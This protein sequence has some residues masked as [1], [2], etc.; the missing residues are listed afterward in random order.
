MVRPPM[1]FLDLCRRSLILDWSQLTLA[2]GLR[3]A[4]AM[5]LVLLAGVLAGEPAAGAVAASG[6]F[7]VGFG[8]F[9]QFTRSHAGPM[10]FALAGTIGSTMLGTFVGHSD[11]G[12]V[13]TVIVFGFW[14]GL[15]P[16]IGMGAYWVGQQTTIYLLVAGAYP[17]DFLH[18]AER[19]GL[20]LAGGLVQLLCYAVIAWVERGA[21][22]RPRLAG[23]MRDAGVAFAGLR[24]HVRMQSPFARFALRVAIALGL[25][26]AAERAVAIPNSYWIALT[27]LLLM[28]PDFQ[29]AIHRGLGRVGGTVLGAVLATA[30]THVL[31][32]D[33][34]VLAVLVVVFAFLTFACL[35]LNF[36]LFAVFA[37]AYV[38]LLLVMAGVAESQVASARVEATFIGAAIALAAHVDFYLRF[39]VKRQAT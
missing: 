39:R 38:V 36:G 25:A 30:I 5:A 19:A 31:T 15:L 12:L 17:G 29:D 34:P 27:T 23:V 22:P 35:R 28:R 16:A 20:V 21:L 32:P 18:A 10:L 1:S 26:V 8:A 6:A 9:Q 3:L 24:F 37:T 33:P 4:P 2:M 7:V 13:L 14:C 11:V